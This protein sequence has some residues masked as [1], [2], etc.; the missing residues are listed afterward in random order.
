MSEKRTQPTTQLPPPPRPGAGPMGGPHGMM[1]R[2]TVVPASDARAAAKR[3]LNRLEAQ[4]TVLYTVLTLT[5]LATGSSLLGPKLLGDA[6]SR[7]FADLIGMKLHQEGAALG[8][9][10]AEIAAK[11]RS[12]GQDRFASM[13]EGMHIVPTLGVDFGAIG[14]LV[15]WVV[16]LYLLSALLGWLQGYLMAGVAQRAVFELRRDVEAKLS[17]VPLKYIDGQSRGDLLSRVTNDIDNIGN[18]LQQGLSQLLTSIVQVVGTLAVMFILSWQLAL[19]SLLIV[20]ISII[21]MARIGKR[22]QAHFTK[23]WAETGKLNGHVEEMHTGHSIVL[24]YNRG[25]RASAEFDEY[26]DALF[27]ASFKAQFLSSIMMPLMNV[28]SNLNYVVIAVLGGIRVASGQL[29]LGQVQAFIQYSRQFTMPLGQIATQANQIQSGLASAERVFQVLDAD[30]EPAEPRGSKT[31]LRDSRGAVVLENVSFRYVPDSPLIEDV[32]VH[33]AP[34]QTVAIV[35]PTGAGKTTIV[36]LLMRFYDIDGGRILLDGIDTRDIAR[37]DLRSEFGMVLQDTWLFNGTIRENIAYGRAGASEDDI[38]RAAKE[39]HADHFIRTL[40]NG[41]DTVLDDDATNISVGER[42]LLTIARA[43]LADPSVLI[44]DEATSNVDTRTEV[45]IQN[46][47][48]RLRHGRTGFV[49]AHRLSTIRNADT[50]LVM[51]HG[52]I[53]EQGSHDEL[54]TAGG[55]YKNLYESQFAE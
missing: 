13:I 34:G 23:Q 14:T 46:A 24:A 11:L 42:Q 36:N 53:I 44:L 2:G 22:S 18:T 3:L 27:E 54:I 45:L 26:N 6:T 15:A 48:N 28:L 9:S 16:G 49:I 37:E 25:E 31:E 43:F 38:V 52:R 12:L 40:P 51:D 35:G 20:P 32:N 30:E 21:M 41:Y 10:S 29:A 5:V 8:T 4:R 17:R 19:V 7:V 33:V 1:G 39:A 47:M 50:I 55:F